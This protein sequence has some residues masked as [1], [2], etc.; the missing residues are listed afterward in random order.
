EDSIRDG[1]VTGVQTCALPILSRKQVN[2]RTFTGSFVFEIGAL[3]LGQLPV[4]EAGIEPATR[5]VSDAR[6]APELLNSG[7]VGTR[8][9]VSGLDRKSVV[10]GN[11]GG[12]GGGGRI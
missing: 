10:E 12:V 2:P 8:T 1:H 7:W 4:V 6:S 5:R 9:R 11:S 3:P